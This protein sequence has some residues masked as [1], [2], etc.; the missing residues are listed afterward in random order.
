V[1]LYQYILQEAR[2]VHINSEH[3]AT[4]TPL[5]TWLAPKG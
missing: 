3:Q 4:R 5:K 1:K 2:S